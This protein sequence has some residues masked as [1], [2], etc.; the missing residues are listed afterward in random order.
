M[1]G[2]FVLVVGTSGSGKGT[3]MGHV[4]SKVSD[5]VFAKSCTTRAMRAGETD[6]SPYF[7]L[8][9]DAFRAK[10]E[11]GEFLEWAEYGGNMYGTLKSEV[12]VPLEEG[13]IVI[14]EME[15]Q[16]ARQVLRKMPRGDLVIIFINAGTWDEMEARILG[17]A[18][19]DA[20]ELLKRKERYDDEMSFMKEADV[21]VVNETGKVEE[22]KR[23]FETAL[24]NIVEKARMS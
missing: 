2:T 4:R 8:T 23:D 6:G 1:K 21:V 12:V 19:M 10:A 11:A 7:F 9:K 18:P 22:A 3:L 5:V 16:G 17:R 14:K 20:H 24:R 15:V 13:K